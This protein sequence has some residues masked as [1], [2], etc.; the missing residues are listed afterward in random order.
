M[1]DNQEVYRLACDLI[2]RRSVTPADEGCQDLLADYLKTS[3]FNAEKMSFGEVQNLWLR[4]GGEQPVVVFAGHTDVVPT[5]PESEWTSPPFEP[6]V[7]DECFYGRGTSDMK[8]SIAAFASA[9]RS[10]VADHPD[11]KGSI[12]ML[13]TSDEEGPAVNGTVK[14]CE[15]LAKR[16]EQ[17][18]YCI[19]GE[20]SSTSKLGDTVKIGRRGS[21]GGTLTVHGQQGHVA[22]PHLALNPVH[23]AAPAL[24]DLT[25]QK[26]DDGNEQFP[27][28]SFQISNINAGTGA[29]NVIP[30]DLK[31]LFN[32]RFSTEST[33]EGLQSKF[34]EILDRHGLKYSLEWN[35][36]GEPFLT[37]KGALSSAVEKAIRQ[38]MDLTPE[39]STSGGTS[40]GRFI[41][42]ICQ[43]VIE[44]GPNNATIHKIDEN[45]PLEEL[46]K[47]EKIYYS[48]LENLLLS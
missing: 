10:F 23:A 46:F 2:S 48:V 12:A 43:D 16:G 27:P 34:E 18:D 42:K 9:A 15:T 28:T 8:S 45:I 35:L 41:A 17:L 38:H 13:I 21:L 22:Y 5:G 4:R 3:G 14:V 25:A 24:A 11:H 39:F 19:V 26:W 32:F 31:I 30:G 20:P 47:L 6:T 29:T 37:Q 33:P 44:L 36:S 40:D 7:R 1:A